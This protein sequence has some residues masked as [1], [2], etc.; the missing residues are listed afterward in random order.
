MTD[1][2]RS[3]TTE[4]V[5]IRRRNLGDADAIITIFSLH[6]GKFDAVAK[7]VRKPTSRMRGHLEPL[8]RVQVHLA[9]GRTLD[10][11]TQA[12]S[13]EAHR[14]LKSD[15][16]RVNLA[17]YCAE[18]SDRFTIDRVEQRPVYEL[19]VDVLKALD[20]GASALAARYFEIHL[21]AIS[22]YEAQVDVCAVCRQKLPEEETLF[23]GPA[24]G[25]VCRQ[26]RPSATSGRIL[27]VRAIKVLRFARTVSV[28]EFD[29]LRV[30]DALAHEL[31]AALTDLI[32]QVIDRELNTS[33]YMDELDR[34]SR[35]PALSANHVQSGQPTHHSPEP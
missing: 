10:V 12:E 4:G 1:R 21:L 2:P 30:S 28:V 25:L 24:G 11:F 14:A 18:L 34:A 32:H 15:L 22:G 35:I 33:R 31:Q 7:G 8:T 29:T 19:L 27:S 13:I 23:S 6:H 26:C 16:D 5:V 20:G 9:R 3:Y 17:L